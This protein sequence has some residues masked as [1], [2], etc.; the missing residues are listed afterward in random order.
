MTLRLADGS[1]VVIQADQ[2][3][4][5]LSVVRPSEG[6]SRRGP[7]FVRSTTLT[8]TRTVANWHS[9]THGIKSTISGCLTTLPWPAA[10][11]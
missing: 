5:A 2:S 8:S 10:R 7:S 1:L 6:A 11:N 4:S 3:C 9:T